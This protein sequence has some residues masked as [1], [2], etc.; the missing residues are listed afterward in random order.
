MTQKSTPT[1]TPDTDTMTAP[2][3]P[4]TVPGVEKSVVGKIP[5]YWDEAA[6][7]LA[8]RQALERAVVIAEH[9]GH[10]TP[11]VIRAIIKEYAND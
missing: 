11:S 10:E 5:A 2:L 6:V 1:H 9:W 4:P 8:V 3:P 7:K